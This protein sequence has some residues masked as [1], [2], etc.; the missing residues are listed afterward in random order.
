MLLMVCGFPNQIEKKVGT[1][2][3]LNEVAL[4]ITAATSPLPQVLFFTE[5][6]KVILLHFEC[7]IRKKTAVRGK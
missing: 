5:L 2:S 3:K 6:L 4:S 1:F 7:I